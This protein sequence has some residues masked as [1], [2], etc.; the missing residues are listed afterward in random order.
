MAEWGAF[1]KSTDGSLLV[2]PDT[3]CYEF[4]K[5]YQP[6]SRVG[7]VNTYS[8]SLA[9]T[10][11]VFVNCGVGESAGLLSVEAAGSDRWTVTA[12]TTKSCSILVFR[13]IQGDATGHGIAVYGKTGNLLFDSSRN[14]LNVRNAGV[15]SEDFSVAAESAVDCIS[16]T[17]GPVYPSSTTTGRFQTVDY[18]AVWGTTTSCNWEN[19]CTYQ[20]LC[21]TT[22]DH[23]SGA[24]TMSC[25]NVPYCSYQQVC[26][27]TPA[28][29]TYEIYAYIERITWIIRRGV[30]KLSANS[31]VKFDWLEHKSG[32]YDVVKYLSSSNTNMSVV[33]NGYQTDPSAFYNIAA[34]SGELNRNSTYPYT[35]DR[36]N[37]VGMV[38]LTAAS[39]DY[40]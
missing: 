23:F 2:T 22:Y 16:Y 11:L 31:G 12:L 20:Y 8:V 19:V 26:T 10:P 38:C 30:A 5:E 4:S 6:T 33:P 13:T 35:T 3:A 39:N 14:V 25:D 36:A 9:E 27:Q 40:V 37:S 17:C 7:N 34:V 1:I 29:T 28:L 18:Y 21:T 24:P 15:L 32:Y